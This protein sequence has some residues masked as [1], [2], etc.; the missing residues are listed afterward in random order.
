MTVAALNTHDTP[1]FAGWAGATDVTEREL[2]GDLDQPNADVLRRVR[3][4]QVAALAPLLG[5]TEPGAGGAGEQLGVHAHPHPLLGAFLEWLASS[6]AAAVL[7]SL[8]DLAGSSEP[9]NVPGTPA[10]RPNWVARL[11]LS[12]PALMVDPV[13]EEILARVGA[14]RTSA[15]GLAVAAGKEP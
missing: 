3:G 15:P 8:D 1:T 9:Q 5:S 6:E 11:P 4:D 14:A 2:A 12:F 13:V 7:V 10:S